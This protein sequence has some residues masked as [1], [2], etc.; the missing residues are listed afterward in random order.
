MI[1]KEFFGF[2]WCECV[3]QGKIPF[4]C[5]KC[6]QHQWSE[7]VY[8]FKS[9]SRCSNKLNS[10]KWNKRKLVK[11]KL[12]SK[13]QWIEK[14]KSSE[15]CKIQCGIIQC[16]LSMVFVNY[17]QNFCWLGRRSSN[18]S[19]LNNKHTHELWAIL[20]RLRL[21]KWNNRVSSDFGE[22]ISLHEEI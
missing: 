14:A 22:K 12:P 6:R 19:C 20:F 15:D 11:Q 3:T 13:K 17:L 16:N 21:T 8:I 9:N 10:I 1:N 18:Y 4:P 2:R 7:L 5:V